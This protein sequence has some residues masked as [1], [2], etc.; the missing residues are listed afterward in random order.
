M[1]I[2]H[3]LILADAIV[4]YILHFQGLMPASKVTSA[5]KYLHN[6]SSGQSYDTGVD[7]PT[8]EWFHLMKTYDLSAGTVKVYLNSALKKTQSTITGNIYSS[9]NSD[10][11]F[12]IAKNASN[13][14]G[15]INGK[16]SQVRVYDSVLTDAQIIDDYSTHDYLY[17]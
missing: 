10:A 1:Q 17:I 4:I 8:G 5:R 7:I 14:N 9:G 11:Y 6:G 12:R 15:Y 2:E 16:I 13:N 3:H